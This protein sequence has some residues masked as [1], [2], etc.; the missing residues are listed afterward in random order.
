MMCVRNK[1]KRWC[2]CSTV[3]LEPAP[4]SLVQD[5]WYVV[6]FVRKSDGLPRT[7]PERTSVQ[8]TNNMYDTFLFGR[9]MPKASSTF[10]PPRRHSGT[11]GRTTTL[12]ATPVGIWNIVAL[13][14]PMRSA[15]E[16]TR[17]CTLWTK[18]VGNNT[19]NKVARGE[20]IAHCL[21]VPS[22]VDWPNVFKLK[23]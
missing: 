14:G 12:P 11:S 6:L 13:V 17:A 16:A 21:D 5:V 20:A 8:A 22:Y 3:Q 2:G 7:K 19:I 4:K 9:T 1:S 10:N 18:V 15:A 23:H